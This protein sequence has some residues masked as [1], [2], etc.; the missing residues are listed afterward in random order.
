[1]HF[2][3][4]FTSSRSGMGWQGVSWTRVFQVPYIR[5]FLIL[6][7]QLLFTPL[8]Q[9][10][11]ALA[12]LDVYM[13]EPEPSCHGSTVLLHDRTWVIMPC[14]DRSDGYTVEPEPS[15]PVCYG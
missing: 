9:G 6:A 14:F 11:R 2:S 10:H 1:M 13:V 7:V 12:R 3:A 8:R 4:F 15:G 5:H